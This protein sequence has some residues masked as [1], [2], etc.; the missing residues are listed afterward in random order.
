[1]D[2]P[3]L[4]VVRTAGLRCD[5]LEELISAVQ[6]C[7]MSLHTA[8]TQLLFTATSEAAMQADL[9]ILLDIL[10]GINEARLLSALC[11]AS[12]ATLRRYDREHTHLL[13]P[14]AESWTP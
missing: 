12:L 11:Q 6:P 8:A 10:F 4:A 13:R 7:N 2:Q 1:M 3:L 5:D 14:P 9:D